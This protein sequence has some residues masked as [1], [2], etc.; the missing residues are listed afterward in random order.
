MPQP[1]KGKRFGGSSS[2]QKAIMS[3][4]T[5]ALIWDGKVTTTIAKAKAV[6]PHAEKIITKAKSGTLHDRTGPE[7]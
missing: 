7:D 2:H 4:L 5:S 3:N 6:R 1:T